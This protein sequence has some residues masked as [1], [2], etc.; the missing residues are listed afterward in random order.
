MIQ[1][2]EHNRGFIDVRIYLDSETCLKENQTT[3]HIDE[4]SDGK[5]NTGLFWRPKECFV[6]SNQYTPKS[7]PRISKAAVEVPDVEDL[8][9]HLIRT[10]NQRCMLRLIVLTRL[11]IVAPIS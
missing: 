11:S 9:P 3:K 2:V 8:T 1:G 7:P 6:F 4:N 5:M 10:S